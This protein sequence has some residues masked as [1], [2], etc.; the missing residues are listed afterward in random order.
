ME[1][2][3]RALQQKKRKKAPLTYKKNKNVLTNKKNT[4][5]NENGYKSS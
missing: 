2:I 3:L 5:K 4:I 1:S